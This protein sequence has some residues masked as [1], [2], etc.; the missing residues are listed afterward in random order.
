MGSLSRGRALAT[1]NLDRSAARNQ[2]GV[3]ERIDA[4]FGGVTLTARAQ[5][6]T[7]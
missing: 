3:L 4:D 7:G 6:N 1:R 5:T 2:T